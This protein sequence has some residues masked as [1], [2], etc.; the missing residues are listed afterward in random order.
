MKEFAVVISRDRHPNND[1]TV[2]LLGVGHLFWAKEFPAEFSKLCVSVF[3]LIESLDRGRQFNITVQIIDPDGVVLV[4]QN[5]PVS[6][7]DDAHH[8]DYGTWAMD[9]SGV[10]INAPGNLDIHVVVDNEHL[11]TAPI[12]FRMLPSAI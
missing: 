12:A 7:P 4:S 9:F 10:G 8:D 6:I 1:G 3:W 2:D 11:L 5:G